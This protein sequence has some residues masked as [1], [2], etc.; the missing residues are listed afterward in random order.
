MKH[1]YKIS[2]GILLYLITLSTNSL[3]QGPVLTGNITEAATGNTVGYAYIQN[4]SRQ[5]TIYSNS[6]GNFKIEAGTGDTLVLYSAGYLYKKVVV[7]DSM[8]V[9]Q[10]VHFTLE[11]PSYRLDEARII[12]IGSYSDLKNRIIDYDVPA[13]LTEELNKYIAG[14]T[15]NE[16]R[17]A[18]L[19]AEAKR[20]SEG[21]T[22]ATVPI[23]TPEEIERKK[24][25]K[26]IVQ[27]QVKDQVYQKFNPMMVKKITG[28]TN[29]DVIIEFMVFCRFSEKYLLEVN[30][31][32]LANRIGVKFELFQ[33]K[34]QEENT[35]PNPMN[36]V[37]VL[38]TTFA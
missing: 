32:D 28:L 34:K 30:E 24:L 20:H 16:A 8:L 26:I 11:I 9:S 2:L 18:Y 29:D 3:G 5:Q 7:D 25:A 6:K 35:E 13:T 19:Q 4:F 15:I 14:I 23:L 12:A 33:I 17:E 38:S 21:V 10:P 27:Q 37:D 1:F 36:A 22:I 31:Y